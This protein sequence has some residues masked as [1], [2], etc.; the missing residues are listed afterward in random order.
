MEG[1]RDVGVW[2]EG[3]LGGVG[4]TQNSRLTCLLCA[5]WAMKPAERPP[6]ECLAN[7]MFTPTP[8]FWR[9]D[10]H[11]AV[12]VCLPVSSYQRRLA[13]FDFSLWPSVFSALIIFII[14]FL[15]PNVNCLAG[16]QSRKGRSVNSSTLSFCSSEFK[17]GQIR[18]QTPTHTHTHSRTHTHTHRIRAD[19]PC[20]PAACALDPELYLSLPLNVPSYKY[21][22]AGAST[23]S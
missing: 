6:A 5:W 19:S 1:D 16:V 10:C 2:L 12:H 7:L 17:V 13:L 22:L 11:L 18:L 8:N 21:W 20:G 15:V 14:I 4:T 9:F 23:E 3:L